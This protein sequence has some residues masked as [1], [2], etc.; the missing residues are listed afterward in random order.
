MSLEPGK[1]GMQS[2][3][4]LII[5]DKPRDW[6]LDYTTVIWVTRIE[7]TYCTRQQKQLSVYCVYDQETH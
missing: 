1:G 6:F 7:A 3:W 5:H 4:V 2:A